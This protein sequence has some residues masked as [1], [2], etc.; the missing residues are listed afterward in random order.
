MLHRENH[1]TL[2]WWASTAGFAFAG[3]LLLNVPCKR[4]RASTLL[5]LV[6]FGL[7]TL[8]AC[9]GGSGSSNKPPPDPGTPFGKYTVVVTAS[10]GSLKHTASFTLNV[11]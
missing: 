6:V 7:L 5:S 8:S 3:I 2:A 9:G 4:R 10:S 1:Q 11:Q